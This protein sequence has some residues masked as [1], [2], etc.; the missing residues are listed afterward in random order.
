MTPLVAIHE[1]LWTT[2]AVYSAA[3]GLWALYLAF[4]QQNLSPNFW[5]ALVINELIFVVQA[6][7]GAIILVQ[8]AQNARW[9]HYL[10][11]ITGVLTIPAAYLFTRGRGTRQEASTYGLVCL[12]LMG[13]AIRAVTTVIGPTN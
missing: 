1:R 12:F 4:K 7:L 3:V 13:I 9:V 6:V 2:A 11:V 10:Y 8:A 5:G